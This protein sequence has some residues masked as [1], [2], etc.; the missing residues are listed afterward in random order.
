MSPLRAGTGNSA[1]ADAGAAG[2]EAATAAI[3]SLDGGDPAL[4]MAWAS[5]QYDLQALVSGIR[6]V[7]GSTPLVGA[8]TW[9]H[10]SRGV[11]APPC[12]GVAVLALTSGG[13]RF[14]TASATGLREHPFETGRAL[15]RTAREAAGSS[16]L[17]HAALILLADGLDNDL[18]EM[19][20][21]IYRVAGAAVPVVGGAASDD[22]T[23]TQTW[24]MHDDQVLG[25][26]AVAV[27]VASE[28]PLQIGCGHGWTPVS[29][30]M[31]VTQSNGS[32][33]E[34]ID[35][36]PALEVYLEHVMKHVDTPE[37]ARA[38]GHGRSGSHTPHFLGLIEPD[39]TQLVRDSN[40]D[41]DG[42]LRTFVPLPPFAAV[43]VV[44]S[45]PDSLLGVVDSVVAEAIPKG[46]EVGVLLA[47]SCVSRHVILG[48]RV[49]EEA[50]LLQAAA[51]G[52]PTFG[53][54]T[55]GEFARTVGVSG[56]HNAT[57]TVI[58]L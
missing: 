39:G 3:A 40:V 8:S 25:D 27:W 34:K 37:E 6:E 30:P 19:L 26:A 52:I 32:V 23:L 14:G 16:G 55:Y 36:R 35:G 31:M 15:A 58:A 56:V 5:I 7:T 2:R 22:L 44:M 24:V 51:G 12:T 43:Q 54:H 50:A 57:L 20:N 9:A 48:D 11:L 45:E 46:R 47:F 21:G 29:L 49:G 1:L 17:P 13:Y 4:I 53:F 10:F 33:V 28:Y 18:Q 42:N 41:A 38:S